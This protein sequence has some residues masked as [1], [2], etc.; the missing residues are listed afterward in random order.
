MCYNIGFMYHVFMEPTRRKERGNFS[1]CWS[2]RKKRSEKYSNCPSSLTLDRTPCT[3]MSGKLSNGK[4][5]VEVG[6][7]SANHLHKVQMQSMGSYIHLETLLSHDIVGG[8]YST[9]QVKMIRRCLNKIYKSSSLMSQG[10]ANMICLHTYLK[11][12]H[13]QLVE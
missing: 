13:P 5:G 2:Y 4:F 1:K 6:M 10:E 3:S 11:Q 12:L 9:C 7:R 8:K